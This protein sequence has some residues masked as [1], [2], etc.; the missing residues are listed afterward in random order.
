M[1]FI[2]LCDSLYIMLLILPPHSTHRLQP[3]DVGLFGPLANFYTQNLNSLLPNSLGIG[4]MSKR[5]FW[6]LFWPAWK[7][8]FT[9]ENIASAFRS[10]GT[11]PYDPSRVLN[12]I[13]KNQPIQASESPNTP[14]KS[15]AV[16]LCASRIHI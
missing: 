4:S 8:A 14:M 6:S 15:R 9:P 2:D 12:K 5:A 1:R 13:T 10:T 11:F 7:R 3:L 16:S